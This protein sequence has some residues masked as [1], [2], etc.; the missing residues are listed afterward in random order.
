MDKEQEEV[1]LTGPKASAALAAAALM[2]LA[3]DEFATGRSKAE[4][5]KF[6]TAK[7]PLSARAATSCA[8]AA[9]SGVGYVPNHILDFL[10]GSRTSQTH[11]LPFLCRTPR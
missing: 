3:E 5:G 10:F 8:L 4:S 1:L 9:I 2:S 7:L 11:L 6:S